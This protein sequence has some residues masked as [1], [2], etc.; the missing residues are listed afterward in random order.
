MAPKDKR[1]DNYIL[2]A[3]DF[4]IPVLEHLRNVVHEAC[5]EVRETIKW[6]FPHFEYKD[7]ILCSMAAFKAHCAFGFWLGS[8]LSDPEGILETR[9]RTA[10]GH[11]GRITSVKELPSRRIMKRYIREAMSLIDK[12]T[13]LEKKVVKAPAGKS[14]EVPAYLREALKKD[15][16]ALSVFNEFSYSKKKDYVEWLTEARTQGTRDK[17]LATALAWIAEGKSR[18]WKYER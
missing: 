4:A 18:H 15:P 3:E 8:Q 17:R 16:A 1:I 11:L 9:E 12:G 10:M 13:R 5:P 7:S 2:R 6:S 14:V